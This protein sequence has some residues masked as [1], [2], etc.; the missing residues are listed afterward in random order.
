MKEQFGYCE[1]HIYQGIKLCLTIFVT[2]KVN[3]WSCDPRYSRGVQHILNKIKIELFFVLYDLILGSKNC[4][5]SVA[6]SLLFLFLSL[7]GC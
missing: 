7:F 5:F 6:A 4:T 1:I 2:F 3:F